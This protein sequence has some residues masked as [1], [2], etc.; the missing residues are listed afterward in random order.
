[1]IRLVQAGRLLLTEHRALLRCAPSSQPSCL[2]PGGATI[3]DAAQLRC[4]GGQ[5]PERADFG[6]IRAARR[7]GVGVGF[8]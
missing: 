2:D 1:M 6:S 7:G 5:R 3:A 4:A 8:L